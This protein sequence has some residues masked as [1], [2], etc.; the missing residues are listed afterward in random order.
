M[1]SLYIRVP[2]FPLD[3]SAMLWKY[4]ELGINIELLVFYQILLI[5]LSSI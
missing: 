5:K 4:G 1:I 3:I 2:K